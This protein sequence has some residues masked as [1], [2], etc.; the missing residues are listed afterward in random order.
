MAEGMN[1]ITDSNIDEITQK[2]SLVLIDCW[3]EWCGPCQMLTPILQQLANE[4]A[5]RVV[6]GKLNVDE[7]PET[8]MKHQ[9]MAIPTI[10]FFKDGKL[11]DN[12][13]GVAPKKQIEGTI[14]KY[15]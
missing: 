2:N 1:H 4:Y 3:A 6:I 15:L 5:G 13:I 10:L 7:N 11:V 14:A 8:S 9:I 12:M